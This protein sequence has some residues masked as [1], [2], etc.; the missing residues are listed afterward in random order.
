[1]A[2]IVILYATGGSMA[3]I[4]ACFLMFF[5]VSTLATEYRVNLSDSA[6][7]ELNYSGK[8]TVDVINKR[9]DG[10][11]YIIDLKTHDSFMRRYSYPSIK[12]TQDQSG[13]GKISLLNV[14]YIGPLSSQIN[15]HV[16][17]LVELPIEINNRLDDGNWLTKVQSYE[18]VDTI[19]GPVMAWK[20]KVI[21]TY[22]SKYTIVGNI[23]INENH[24]IVKER[25]SLDGWNMKLDLN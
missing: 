16:I 3:K 5:T 24:G 19:Y 15:G 25:C 4:T 9:S 20:L 23:W 18:S 10:N 14:D 8:Y 11:S 17:D 6:D 21:G 22:R 12:I 2:K 7:S 13:R 1:M